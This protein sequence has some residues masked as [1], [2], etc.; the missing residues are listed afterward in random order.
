MKAKVSTRQKVLEAAT[1]IVNKFGYGGLSISEVARQAKI[2]KQ[3]LFY[4]FQ[5]PEEI[6]LVLAENWSRAGQSSTLKALAN[7]HEVGAMKILAMSEGMFAWMS[8]DFALARLGL[9][10]YLSSPHIKKL[11]SFMEAARGAGRGRIE[12]I[13][14]QDKIFSNYSK[15]KME[16]TI[17][18]IHSVMHGYYF[19]IITLDDLKNL[20]IH[21]TN[22]NEA[23]K[24]LI[25]S[26]QE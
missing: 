8:E 24:R 3:S 23:L 26:Y 7:T 4:H 16:K 18:A 10:I 9:A 21:K 11:N 25:Q 14:I 2:S 17:T 6:L 15:S 22:C 19:Y 12:S 1:E 20:E 5:T 13:L